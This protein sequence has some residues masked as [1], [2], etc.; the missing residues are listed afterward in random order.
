[1]L[2]LILSLFVVISFQVSATE[3]LPGVWK[4][5]NKVKINGEELD[6]QKKI[7]DAL[8]MMPE[9]Q[10]KNFLKVM[11]SQMGDSGLASMANQTVCV[12][13]EMVKDPM[14]FIQKDMDCKN[15]IKKD[16]AKLKV[17]DIQCKN[18]SNGI[19][20]WNIKNPKNYHGTFEGISHK[21]EKILINFKGD[22]V[23]AACESI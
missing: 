4:T 15:T 19:L 21:K 12:T 17:F 14:S 7:N 8:A 22:H 3:L 23:A 13:K 20:T 16:E 18:G 11:E 6:I 10:R 9:A 1:M 2:H 5:E